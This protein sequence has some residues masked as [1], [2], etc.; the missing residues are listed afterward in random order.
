MFLDDF[1]GGRGDL[2]MGIERQRGE[3]SSRRIIPRAGRGRRG[4]VG[5]EEGREVFGAERGEMAAVEGVGIE[6]EDGFAG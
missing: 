1:V 6:V 2:D 4:R 5:A 3:A